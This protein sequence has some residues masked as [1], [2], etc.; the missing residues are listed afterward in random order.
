MS[1][2]EPEFHNLPSNE[3]KILFLY[4]EIFY[5]SDKLDQIFNQQR[6]IGQLLI[7]LISEY[8]TIKDFD[9]KFLKS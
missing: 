9:N 8:K 4:K 3:Q 2:R 5:M 7:N 1:E 6:D